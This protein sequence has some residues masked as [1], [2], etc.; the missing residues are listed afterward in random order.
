MKVLLAHEYYRSSSP[1]GEDIVFE[2]E[3]ELLEKNGIQVHLVK[4]KNDDIG[5]KK[6]PSVL[7]VSPQ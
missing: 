7:S 3:R 1:S 2:K 4:F 5:T 6:R